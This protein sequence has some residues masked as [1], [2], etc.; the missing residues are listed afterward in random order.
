MHVQGDNLGLVTSYDRIQGNTLSAQTVDML[1]LPLAGEGTLGD[2][3]ND[4]PINPLYDAN[5]HFFG[6]TTL[7]KVYR[8][9]TCPSF[10]Q[11][12]IVTQSSNLTQ[13]HSTSSSALG[14]FVQVPPPPPS[15]NQI[16]TCPNNLIFMTPE[17]EE[18]DVQKALD[19]AQDSITYSQFQDGAHELDK[20]LLLQ[21]LAR[22]TSILAASPIL[23][24]FYHAQF[25]DVIL[26]LNNI[27]QL[28]GRLTDSA[29]VD[30]SAAWGLS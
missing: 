20:D 19:I 28:I 26:E 27:D 7:S 12:K 10:T 5:N 11:D 9:T 24:S 22:D 21:W 17:G 3:G 4:N 30:D 13:A 18:V 15:F 6:N 2:I 14:C 29:L 1:F 8:F 16:F 23:D 25:N